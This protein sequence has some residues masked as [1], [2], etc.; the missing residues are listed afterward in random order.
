MGSY[1]RMPSVA[2]SLCDGVGSKVGVAF[3]GLPCELS[4]AIRPH[5]LQKYHCKLEAERS[6]HKLVGDM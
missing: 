5:L 4:A 2:A 6:H 1:D 3:V